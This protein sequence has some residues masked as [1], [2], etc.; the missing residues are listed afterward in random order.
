MFD[1]L[2]KIFEKI[3]SLNKS[4]DE[5]KKDTVIQSL[6]SLT[7]VNRAKKFIDQKKL[8]EAEKI[9]Q[10]ALELPQ[11]DAL[12]YKYLG[13]V[14]EKAGKFDMA[15]DSYQT[16]AD[17]NPQDRNI[18]QRLGF[19]LISTGKY[20]N[21]L[22]S[23]ENADKIQPG[24]TDTY[25]GWGMAFMKLG[26]YNEA[27]EKFMRAADIYKY[28]FN[29]IFLCAVM[30]IK[31]KMY[32]KADM[33]LAFLANVC[34]DANNTFEFARLKALKEDI[35]NAIHYA[36]KSLEFNPNMLPAYIL[37]GQIYAGKFDFDNA[38]KYFKAAEEKNLVNPLF[39][40]EYGKMFQ[41]FEKY[42]DAKIKFLK[43]L[44]MDSENTE[45]LANLGLCC[46]TRKE[47]DE[48]QPLLE[49]S[50]KKE[51]ENFVVKQALG[52]IAFENNETDKAISFFR[53]NDEEPVNAY[54][55][56]K[57]FER[58]QNDTKVKDYY[59]SAIYHNPKYI[60]AFTDYAKYLILHDEFAEAQ[61]KLRKALK[62]DENNTVL[63]NLMFYASYRLVKD[64]VC[65][66]NV[67]ETILIADKIER[68]NPDLFE[69]SEE[70]LE[71][72]RLL[73]QKPE[74]E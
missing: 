59:E 1:K 39:F 11:K 62:I 7:Y 48:A 2:K 4:L 45:T 29:A 41:K 67:K 42:D 55:L 71:L 56:A 14:Y 26:K 32:D 51:P 74:R 34:P 5:Y 8:D 50:L 10:K 68:I 17:L 33:K 27:R 30:E 60:A 53:S 36:L 21:A 37:L 15:V 20:E 63:L 31:L 47:Y 18:W 52:I 70:K 65:E 40:L 57:C 43:S 22:K 35:N 66:Y 73:P 23:F 72:I 28:N 16:S 64:N 49:K 12:V 13:V 44:E 38:L 69:Y 25:T 3:S 58:L 46:V 6:P 19:M 61:R 9:L 24:N 54:Y